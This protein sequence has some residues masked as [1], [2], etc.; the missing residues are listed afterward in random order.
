MKLV[1]FDSKIVGYYTDRYYFH[2]CSDFFEQ[3]IQDGVIIENHKKRAIM[4]Y[5]A[6]DAFDELEEVTNETK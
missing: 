2:E 4:L 1:F 5:I 6:D 3:A